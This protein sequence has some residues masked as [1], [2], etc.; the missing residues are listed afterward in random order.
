MDCTTDHESTE[1]DGSFGILVTCS[2][3]TQLVPRY[4]TRPLKALGA[5]QH[6]SFAWT[7]LPL[8]LPLRLRV[9][10]VYGTLQDNRY[11]TS[12]QVIPSNAA[13]EM[14]TAKC[15][16]ASAHFGLGGPMSILRS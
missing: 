7:T 14:L 3:E 12:G 13:L 1:F 15:D 2:P 6:T 9:D 4:D 8:P 11:L 10:I 5:A 16:P